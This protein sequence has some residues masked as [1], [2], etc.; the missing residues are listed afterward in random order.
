V[1]D[2]AHSTLDE[3]Q[4]IDNLGTF[5]RR[6]RQLHRKTLLTRYYEACLRRHAWGDMNPA[7][8]IGYAEKKMR[9]A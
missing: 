7:A 9:Q 1:D 4:F 5:N 6:T 8:V 3:C 2:V